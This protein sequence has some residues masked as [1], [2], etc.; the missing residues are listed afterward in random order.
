VLPYLYSGYF[1]YRTLLYIKYRYL[2]A[3]GT[4]RILP[5]APVGTTGTPVPG[6]RDPDL[7]PGI[8]IL[9]HLDPPDPACD[10]PG[11]LD[12]A[13]MVEESPNRQFI[14]SG[15]RSDDQ[16]LLC[17]LCSTKVLLYELPELPASLPWEPATE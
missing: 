17:R 9:V 6:S 16:P 8:R 4:T 1:T 2:M 10:Q 3:A 5:A 14:R 11:I 15:I 13:G 7:D 12:P